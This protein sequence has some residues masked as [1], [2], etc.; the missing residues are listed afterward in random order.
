[1]PV[2]PK[3]LSRPF[4]R[5]VAIIEGTLLHVSGFAFAS[6]ASPPEASSVPS[7]PP[8][9]SCLP[10][11]P[12][13]PPR[14][15]AAP[16]VVCCVGPPFYP[17]SLATL[18]IDSSKTAHA[19]ALF[20]LDESIVFPLEGLEGPGVPRAAVSREAIVPPE[21]LQSLGRRHFPSGTAPPSHFLPTMVHGKQPPGQNGFEGLQRIV[22][23]GRLPS[24][25]IRN[26]HWEARWLHFEHPPVA[27]LCQSPSAENLSGVVN[28]FF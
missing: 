5:H 3:L 18:L 19:G 6:P 21:P 20:I 4:A 12:A 11:R 22:L 2:P 25:W 16:A 24:F 9:A 28:F 10:Q 15:V 7:C 17:S 27:L 14:P 13:P 26:G 1:M 8:V 23:F